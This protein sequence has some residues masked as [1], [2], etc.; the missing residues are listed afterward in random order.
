MAFLEKYSWRG[1]N[2]INKEMYLLIIN[3]RNH[4]SLLVD[5]GTNK[6]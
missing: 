2:K 4:I 6:S 3:L 5:D 1:K